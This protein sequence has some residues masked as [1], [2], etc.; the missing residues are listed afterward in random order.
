[1]TTLVVCRYLW[2]ARAK[3]VEEVIKLLNIEKCADTA[4][5]PATSETSLVTQRF[6]AS[7]FLSCVEAIGDEKM[8]LRGISGRQTLAV[9][10]D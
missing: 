10:L 4:E 6:Y 9:L 5:C 7:R 1:M 3:R 2:Q 8:G